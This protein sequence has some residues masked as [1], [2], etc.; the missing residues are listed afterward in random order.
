MSDWRE[1]L[2]D[3]FSDGWHDPDKDVYDSADEVMLLI[4]EA[5]A[6]AWDEGYVMRSRDEVKSFNERKET[7]NP[8]KEG[9]E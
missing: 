1:K 9:K 5:Q 8:Y 7:P 6:E 2:A 3:M 4:R